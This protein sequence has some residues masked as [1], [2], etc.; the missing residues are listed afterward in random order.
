[1]AVNVAPATA[2][3]KSLSLGSAL[4]CDQAVIGL[5][6]SDEIDGDVRTLGRVLI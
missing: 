1:M 4:Y 2:F 5:S 3:G 6:Y